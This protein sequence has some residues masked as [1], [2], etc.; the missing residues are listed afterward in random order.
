MDNRTVGGKLK[1]ICLN[2]R[3]IILNDGLSGG[4]YG[5]SYNRESNNIIK[6][7]YYYLSI[8]LAVALVLSFSYL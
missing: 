7:T 1:L 4:G 2:S 8:I 3:S 5:T 6:H